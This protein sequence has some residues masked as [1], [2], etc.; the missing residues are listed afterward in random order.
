[1][2]KYIAERP[3]ELASTTTEVSLS[4][5]KYAM[6]GEVASAAVTFLKLCSWMVVH[7]NCAIF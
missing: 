5:S 4:L 3:T 1:M 7:A 6:Q 2:T